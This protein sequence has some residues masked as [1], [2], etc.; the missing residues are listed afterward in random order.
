[1]A[2][3]LTFLGKG[4]VGRTTIAIA[5]AK[6]LA[7][8]GKRVLLVNQGFDPLLSATLNISPSCDPQT[9]DGQFQAIQLQTALL[10]DRAWEEV[11]R[12]ENEYLRS[13]VLK[14]I[15][16]QELAVFPGMDEALALN[17]LREYQTSGNYDVVIYDGQG[18][19]STLRMLGLP[20]T[21]SWYVRRTRQVF[22]ESDFSKM[23]L[24]LL[25]PLIATVFNIDW[26]SNNFSQPASKVND[27]MDQGKA[28]IADPQRMVAYLVTTSQP[29]TIATA[30]YLWGSSQQ[31]GLTVAGVLINQ[32]NAN[33]NEP[34][35]SEAFAPLPVYP[36]PFMQDGDWQTLISALPDFTQVEQAPR[37][38]TVDLVARQVRLF[39]PGFS[40]K[41]VK[42][43]QNGPEVTIEAGDQRRNILLPP[44]LKG[45]P[46]TGAKFQDQS[47]IISF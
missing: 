40:K 15:Y 19:Q 6:Q 45:R 31:T 23:V 42:L 10:L 16:A 21:L 20:E 46:V 18:D 24:P 43:S 3:I 32:P 7:S 37:S 17:A 41:Q 12:L 5:T 27:L 36:L 9:V 33:I 30:Q 2:H 25:Q 34:A 8:Q 47:L 35:E 4:G 38:M 28:A 44:E 14:A 1:M 11:K 39:L 26:A 13:P 29:N 22:A